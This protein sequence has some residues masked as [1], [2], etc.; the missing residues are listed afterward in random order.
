MGMI[1][2]LSSFLSYIASLPFLTG[3]R[4]L[5]VSRRFFLMVVRFARTL[6]E[7]ACDLTSRNVPELR[8]G[9]KYFPLVSLAWSRGFPLWGMGLRAWQENN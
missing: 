4:L 2:F 1:S 5:P 6:A 9:G 8:A 3:C 7:I